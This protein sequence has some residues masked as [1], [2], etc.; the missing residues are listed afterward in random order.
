MKGG[1]ITLMQTMT[2]IDIPVFFS[3]N[4]EDLKH[5]NLLLY[6]CY[7]FQVIGFVIAIMAASIILQTIC[8]T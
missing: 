4:N 8:A 5:Y 7:A 1:A 2:F 6:R 3:L